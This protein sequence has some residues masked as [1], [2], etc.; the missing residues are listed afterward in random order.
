MHR[1]HA[2]L[3]TPKHKGVGIPR[4][5][6][7]A[8]CGTLRRVH[9]AGGG[10]DPVQAQPGIRE[11]AS[12]D[13]R[14]SAHGLEDS[15]ARAPG[16]LCAQLALDMRAGALC[17]EAQPALPL[18]DA[19]GVAEQALARRDAEEDERPKK[20]NKSRKGIGGH[21]KQIHHNEQL[22]AI[23]QLHFPTSYL[24]PCICKSMVFPQTVF[25]L[26]GFWRIVLESGWVVARVGAGSAATLK[27]CK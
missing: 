1:W 9:L 10:A 24:S 11:D 5:A 13:C 23:K 3:I 25:T 8:V 15:L 27:C 14:V 16:N 19:E 22:A 18:Q 2:E 4:M 26:E 12:K 7:Q 21:Y 6:D 20:R 17:D